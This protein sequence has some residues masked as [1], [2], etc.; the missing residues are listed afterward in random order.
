MLNVITRLENPP[1]GFRHGLRMIGASGAV[2]LEE[3]GAIRDLGA[4]HRLGLH[5]ELSP[6]V[7]PDVVGQPDPASRDLG[8]L[9][10]LPQDAQSIIDNPGAL[11]SSLNLVWLT[12]QYIPLG[13]PGIVRPEGVWIGYVPSL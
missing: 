6:Q 2:Q 12:R 10:A 3:N 5:F 11:S 7:G 8:L 13:G 9:V 4:E 1:L